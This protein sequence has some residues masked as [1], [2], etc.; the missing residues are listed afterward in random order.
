[1]TLEELRLTPLYKKNAD[2]YDLNSDGFLDIILTRTDADYGGYYIQIIK[3]L[4][5]N[6]FLDI[7]NEVISDNVLIHPNEEG[8]FSEK[9]I[10]ESGNYIYD[11]IFADTDGDGIMEFF[12]NNVNRFSRRKIEGKQH[13]YKH[14]D[15]INGKFI[16]YD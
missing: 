3:N 11:S 5:G 9:P 7:T 1:M 14:W 13:P 15:L 12:F 4:N 10:E 16:D 8:F 6:E 2:F